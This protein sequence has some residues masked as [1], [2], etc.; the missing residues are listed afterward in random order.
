M[1]LL[2]LAACAVC[3]AALWVAVVVRS[4]GRSGAA[5]RPSPVVPTREEDR[6]RPAVDAT[7]ERIW[8]EQDELFWHEIVCW[9]ARRPP[10]GEREGADRRHTG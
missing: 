3:C 10:S 1:A 4:A 7:G 5:R 9:P 6:V 8:L 2:E